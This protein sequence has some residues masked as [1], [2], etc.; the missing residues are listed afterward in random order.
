MGLPG[1]IRDDGVV[2]SS[3][4][5]PGWVGVPAVAEM[6]RRLHIPILVDNDANLGA[7]AEAAFGAAPDASDLIY[8]RVSSRIG[9]RLVLNGR[10][11]G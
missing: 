9:A 1:P 2:G 5:L 4:I 10:L 6:R 3:A 8:L 11:S 7:P